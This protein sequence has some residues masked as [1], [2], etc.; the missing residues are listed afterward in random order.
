M[1]Y[2]VKAPEKTYNGTSAS[3]SFRDGVGY[4]D[5]EHLAEWFKEHGYEVE[6]T[7][8]GKKQPRGKAKAGE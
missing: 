8:E 4:T 6:D 1:R 5:S 7:E 2:T 3:V